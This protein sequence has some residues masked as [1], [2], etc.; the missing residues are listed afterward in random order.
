MLKEV[1]IKAMTCTKS[2]DDV[3]DFLQ[4]VKNWETGGIL[5]S[6]TRSGNNSWT[7]DRPMGKAQILCTK[8]GV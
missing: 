8:Q 2:I 7:C 5:K 6:I 4:D 3:Y 1:V